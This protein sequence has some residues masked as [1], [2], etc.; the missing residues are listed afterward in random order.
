[1][2]FV[3][4]RFLFPLVATVLLISCAS[5]QVDPTDPNSH[6]IK[7]VPQVYQGA[8]QCSAASLAMIMEY[9]SR[10]VS[11]NELYAKLP[12]SPSGGVGCQD[13]QEFPSDH[14]GM[15]TESWLIENPELIKEYISQDIPVIARV[16]SDGPRANCHYVVVV[17]YTGEGFIINDPMVGVRF[18]S[19][20]AFKRWQKCDYFSCPPYWV[21]IVTPPN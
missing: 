4:L 19:Y 13:L 15:I 21:L 10:K 7:G 8:M 16:I 3:I 20:D 14:L 6:L 2:R 5:V 18:K 11:M 12:K 1:M 17:G 9:H